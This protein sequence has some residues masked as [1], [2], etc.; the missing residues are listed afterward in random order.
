MYLTG[1]T[2]SFL[3]WAGFY[4][5]S[6][7]RVASARLEKLPGRNLVLRIIAGL[8]ALLSLFPFAKGVGLERGIAI[9]LGSLTLMGVIFLFTL[10]THPKLHKN[11]MLVAMFAAPFLWLASLF[12]AL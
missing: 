10:Q 5:A 6:P 2:F 9:W 12:G 11:L 8:L 3:S 4:A 7:Q 1:A